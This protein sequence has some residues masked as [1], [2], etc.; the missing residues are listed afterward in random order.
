[1]DV[2]QQRW[3]YA[4]ALVNYLMGK[5]DIHP[6]GMSGK[7]MIINSHEDSKIH[8]RDCDDDYGYCGK[9]E[10]EVLTYKAYSVVKLQSK[11][12]QARS[13]Q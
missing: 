7:S 3:H 8:F 5:T 6:L 9:D 13:R 1:M 4:K 10:V 2:Y 11:R 12:R